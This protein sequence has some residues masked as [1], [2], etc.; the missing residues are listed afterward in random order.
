MR[1]AE[2][3]RHTR[4]TVCHSQAS[5]GT[6]PQPYFRVFNPTAQSEKSDVSGDYIR[7]WVPE[8]AKLKGKGALKQRPTN[9]TADY[10]GS[11]PFMTRPRS[12]Q[13]KNS[14]R[15]AT[16]PR[17]STTRRRACVPSLGTRSELF[18]VT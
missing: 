10:D 18:Y 8:L 1:D 9:Y 7:H 4:L 5:T 2:A 13:R 6:D 16:R 17:S 11:Q 3:A 14:P 15:L 12:C